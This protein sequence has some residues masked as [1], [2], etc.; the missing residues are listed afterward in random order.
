M[1]TPG[2]ALHAYILAEADHCEHETQARLEAWRDGWRA[3]EIAHSGQYETG[4]TDAQ[5]DR[6][7]LEHG[8][9]RDLQQHLITW[10]GLR[11]NFSQPR[12][13]DY[14]GQAGAT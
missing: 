10:D 3:C 5:A 7:A 11:E 12:P 6:K 4:Y 8:A 14:P 1:T 13:G 2:Q 9:V